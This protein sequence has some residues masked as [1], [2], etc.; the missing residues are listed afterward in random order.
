MKKILVI[1]SVLL[2]VSLLVLSACS[3]KEETKTA[4]NISQDI[5]QS[6]LPQVSESKTSQAKDSKPES[7]QAEANEKDMQVK[8]RVNSNLPDIDYTYQAIVDSP[9]GIYQSPSGHDEAYQ[10][11]EKQWQEEVK[12]AIQK[13]EPKLD[14]EASEEEIQHLFKQYLYLAAY[15]YPVIEPIERYSYVVFKDDNEDPFSKKKINE[16]V[17]INLEIALDCSGSMANTIGDKTIMD[18]AKE[19]IKKVVSELPENSKVGLRVFGHKGNNKGS[20]KAESCESCELIQPIEMVNKDKIDSVLNPISPTGWTCIAKSIE[21]GSKD[22]SAFTGEK[23][24]NILFIV[25]DG[26]ETC[27]GNPVEVAKK[28]KGDNTNIVL[29]I[30]GF[31]VSA[32]QNAVLKE[33]AD[34]GG[35]YYASAKDAAELSSELETIHE[36]AYSDYKWEELDQSLLNELK[37]YQEG[38]LLH[39]KLQLGNGPI[40]EKNDLTKLINYSISKEAGLIPPSGKVEKRLRE[41]VEERFSKITNII[42]DEYAKREQESKEYREKVASRLGETVAFIPTTSRLNPDSNYFTGYSNKGGDS[43]GQEKDAASLEASVNPEG[44]R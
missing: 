34:A 17:N 40:A 1:L 29:G 3:D 9:G 5:T 21:E 36:L 37:R 18:I 16:N 25:T 39:N 27:G 43:K 11:K 15:D 22:L 24:L 10:E 19:S 30:I 4:E 26:I 20:G 23:D 31:N 28:L 12:Q 42:N 33:V 32:N 41:L 8:D 6:K 13:I 2:L 38:G 7:S 14:D 35:G 44:K